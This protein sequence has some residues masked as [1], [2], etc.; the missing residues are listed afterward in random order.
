MQR[1]RWRATGRPRG[2]LAHTDPAVLQGQP[3]GPQSE[4]YSLGVTLLQLLTGME[5]SGLVE[6]VEAAAA[7][8]RLA[9]VVDPCAG[10]WDLE[11][12]SSLARLALRFV[13][14]CLSTS[15]QA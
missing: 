9:D 10:D 13:P 8:G 4:V 6:H 14:T 12:A 15:T 11:N 5:A 7:S 1:G 3:Y 2:A